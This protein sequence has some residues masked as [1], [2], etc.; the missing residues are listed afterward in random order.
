M[1]SPRT[2]STVGQLLVL[3]HQLPLGVIPG[4][5]KSVYPTCS[6]LGIHNPRGWWMRRRA[7]AGPVAM[8][9]GLRSRSLC[10]DGA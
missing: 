8:D 9:S 5:Y 7:T 1:R 6:E 2:D 3:R 4:R 10:S